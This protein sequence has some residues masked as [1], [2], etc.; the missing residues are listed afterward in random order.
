MIPLEASSCAHRPEQRAAAA[1][2]YRRQAVPIE[3][4]TFAYKV[5]IAARLPVAPSILV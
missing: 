5:E 4:A 1:V 3:T 2:A